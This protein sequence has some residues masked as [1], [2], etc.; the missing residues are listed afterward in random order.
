MAE[1]EGLLLTQVH[2]LFYV[3][4]ECKATL[5][6]MLLYH[7]MI[8]SVSRNAVVR[9]NSYDSWLSVLHDSFGLHKHKRIVITA[10]C[11]C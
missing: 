8:Q 2:V 4:L 10:N 6:V 1:V 7:Q 9:L 3:E 5:A 11:E